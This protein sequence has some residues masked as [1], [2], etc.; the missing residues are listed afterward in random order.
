MIF[1]TRIISAFMAVIMALV[2]LNGTVNPT[3]NFATLG[4]L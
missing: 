3:R 1:I 4:P 2:T